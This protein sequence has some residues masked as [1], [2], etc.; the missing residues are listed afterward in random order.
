[1]R[2]AKKTPTAAR[3][4]S[5]PIAE[6]C[7]PI[8]EFAARGSLQPAKQGCDAR[9]CRVEGKERGEGDTRVRVRTDKRPVPLIGEENSLWERGEGSLETAIDAS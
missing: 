8:S 9:G 6:I 1:M 7:M 2:S 5:A 4:I 3:L